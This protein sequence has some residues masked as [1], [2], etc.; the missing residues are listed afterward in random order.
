TSARKSSAVYSVNG[1]TTKMPALATTAS[2]EPNFLR[3]RPATFCAGSICPMSASINARWSEAE[4]SLDFVALRAVTTTWYPRAR[5]AR[6]IP[7]PMPCD[8]PVTITVLGGLFTVSL[9]KIGIASRWYKQVPPFLVHEN[10]NH[11]LPD[12]PS[13]WHSHE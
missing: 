12:E 11:P 9:S 8:A 3:A 6:T 4:S 1:F 13:E 7:A 10:S 2:I 5:N